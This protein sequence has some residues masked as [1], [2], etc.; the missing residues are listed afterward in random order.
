MKLHRQLGIYNAAWPAPQADAGDDPA[1]WLRASPRPALRGKTRRRAPFPPPGGSPCLRNRGL[2]SFFAAPDSKY[3]QRYLAEFEYRFNRRFD[4][5]DIIPRLVYGRATPRRPRCRRRSRS[6]LLEGRSG[7]I[8]LRQ[9][10]PSRSIPVPGG[11]PCLRNRGLR[12]FFAA[13]ARARPRGVHD[14]VEDR[15][16]IFWKGVVGDPASRGSPRVLRASTAG[17]SKDTSLGQMDSDR[18]LRWGRGPHRPGGTPPARRLDRDD[19]CQA[20]SPRRRAQG[21]GQVER[22]SFM[23]R[24]IHRD[25]NFPDCSVI[26]GNPSTE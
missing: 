26:P 5:P 20:L 15:G 13:P 24:E 14:V 22:K 21:D 1:R 25:G 9:N 12:S 6:D 16:Q 3:A 7:A 4:L 18:S 10:A 11:S 8:R 19:A 2:R 17:G 23:R